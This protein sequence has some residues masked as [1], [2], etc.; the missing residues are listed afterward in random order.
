MTIGRPRET[1]RERKREKKPSNSF[2]QEA[3]L[4]AFKFEFLS[5]VYCYSNDHYLLEASEAWHG[6]TSWEIVKVKVTCIS[7]PKLLRISRRVS[8]SWILKQILISDSK[9]ECTTNRIESAPGKHLIRFVPPELR[10]KVVRKWNLIIQRKV[11]GQW[12]WWINHFPRKQG[13]HPMPRIR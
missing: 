12:R 11:H 10:R 1:T 8:N 13:E 2:I 6:I 7:Q 4:S 5:D 9:F 3:H